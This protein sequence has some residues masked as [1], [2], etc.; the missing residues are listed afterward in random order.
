MQTI[1][2]SLPDIILEPMI[3][4][5]LAEDLGQYG[6]ITTRA[7][8][9]AGMTYEA[10]LNARENGVVSGMQ[11]AALTFRLVDPALK[12]TTHIADGSI[13][14]PGDTLMTVKFIT[15]FRLMVAEI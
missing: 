3:R 9:P 11:V 1:Y 4:N 8:I 15:G 13:C 5:A 14:K 10:R 12:I 6:Y 2:S 7:V